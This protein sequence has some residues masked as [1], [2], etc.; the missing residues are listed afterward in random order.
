MSELKGATASQAVMNW[1]AE[2]EDEMRDRKVRDA[3]R[4]TRVRHCEVT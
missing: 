1:F 2:H 3:D 4:N